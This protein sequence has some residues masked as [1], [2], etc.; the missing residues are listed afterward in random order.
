[1]EVGIREVTHTRGGSVAKPD[2]ENEVVAGIGM[3]GMI[4]ATGYCDKTI[5]KLETLGVVSPQ[6]TAWGARLF[7]SRDV[8]AANA[9]RER[10]EK[11]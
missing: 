7:S 8:R 11:A 9:W 6:Y 2:R 1:M 4:A 10:H 5:K 3:T